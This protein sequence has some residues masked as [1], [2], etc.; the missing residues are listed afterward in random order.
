MAIKFTI[1]SGQQIQPASAANVIARM[2]VVANADPASTIYQFA[3][4]QDVSTALPG[5]PL[6][7]DCQYA[8][9]WSGA[10]H[11]GCKVPATT[12]GAISAV[13]KPGGSS[14]PSPTIAGS[15]FDSVSNS[16]YDAYSA[17]LQYSGGAPGACSV[18][19]ALD[20]LA[21]GATGSY[22]YTYPI[23]ALLP[24]SQRGTVDVTG[25]TWATL[26]NETLLFTPDGGALVTVT[27]GANVAG[28]ADVLS[29]FSGHPTIT[30]AFV[31]VGDKRYLQVNAI[32]LGSVGA[33][34]CGAGTAD[35]NLGFVNATT[36]NGVNATIKIPGTGLTI[37]FPSG[38]Y[39][40]EVHT[41]T[42]TAPRHSKADF[43][44]ALA[45]L[46][47]RYDLAFGIVE[48]VQEPVDATDLAQYVADTDTTAAAWEAQATKRFV[49]FV[50]PAPTSLADSA[51]AG[52]LVS[53]SGRYTTVAA[54]S[55]YIST[56]KGLPQGSFKRSVARALTTR[57]AA[58]PYSED[59][60]FGGFGALPGCSMLG[61][62]G[63]TWAPDENSATTKLGT[64]KGPGYTV[65]KGKAINGRLLPYIVRGVT[66]AGSG[67]LFVDIGVTR[68]ILR[69]AA[70]IF[71]QLQAIENP[72]FDLNPDG[73]IQE[74]DAQSLEDT[75]RQ[76]LLDELVPAHAS[77]A[78][79]SINRDENISQTRDLTVSYTVQERGQGEDITGTL[80]LT[81][82]IAVIS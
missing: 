61:P 67:S 42:T 34:V 53:E 22:A 65:V 32:T 48:L 26:D 77:A 9:T 28:E 30:A 15:T 6:A 4:G 16:P 10:Q 72:T 74:S 46:G 8:S 63:Q 64:S 36:T 47:G 38:T 76:A 69:A 39:L 27:F 54:R 80:T 50:V 70:I 41:F 51:V 35:A 82:T 75:W 81:G 79:V 73:K 40:A 2:G 25:I 29:A 21:G 11:L 55:L 57:L 1:T 12:A 23:P 3:I 31:Q 58:I 13:T 44:T 5:G 66:R 56:P 45:V 71:A 62:D 43:D 68:M 24:A 59:P 17:A 14:S 20:Y 52:A 60:G 18:N 78:L 33:L 7:V 49:H 19:V 37:T